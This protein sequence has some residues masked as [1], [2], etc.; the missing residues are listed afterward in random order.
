MKHLYKMGGVVTSILLIF[1]LLV[2]GCNSGD[3]NEE[4]VEESQ[5]KVVSIP[6]GTYTVSGF[7]F[8]VS[9]SNSKVTDSD[10]KDV[11]TIDS[12]GK[13]TINK[14]ESE[15]WEITYDNGDIVLVK[16]EKGSSAKTTYRGSISGDELVNV[17]NSGD[18]LSFDAEISE[19]GFVSAKKYTVTVTNGTA[20]PASAK[21]GETVT[22]SADTPEDGFGFYKWTSETEG[23]TLANE[24][25]S[26]T[27]FVMPERDVSITA[28]YK[29]KA[30]AP[31]ITQENST[32]M[33]ASEDT[34]SDGKIANEAITTLMEYSTDDG[35]TWISVESDG[36]I[37]N[38]CSGTILIRVKATEEKAPSDSVSVF[39]GAKERAATP[40]ISAE[41][42]TITKPSTATSTNGKIENEAITTAMEYSTNG[43]ETWHDVTTSGEIANLGAGTVLIRVK[44]TEEKA[45]S[46]S[47]SIVVGEKSKAQTPSISQENSTVTKV[48]AES[49]SDGKIANEAITT[50][51]EYSTDDGETW[52]DVTTAGEIANLA[53][54][55]V[56]V[57]TKESAEYAPSD[58]VSIEIGVM[59]YTVTITN[60]TASVAS[61]KAGVEVTVTANAAPENKVF[62]KW[63]SEG[64]ATFADEKSSE[65][66]FTMPAGN[67]SITA[68]YKDPWIGT[69]A[70]DEPKAVGDIVFYDGSATPY[71]ADL[72]LTEEE[73]LAAIAVIFYVGTE[74]SNADSSGN[75]ASR[76]LGVGLVDGSELL[77]SI[78]E[79]KG[80]EA[81]ITT[82]QC[83]PSGTVDNYT[84]TGDL[85]GSDNFDAIAA[86]PG[87]NDTGTESN[88]PAFYFAKN[89]K[90][91]KVGEESSSRI[92]AGSSFETGWYVP[93]IAELY[94]VYENRIILNKARVLCGGL[95]FNENQYCSSSQFAG[96]AWI[97]YKLYFYY[98]TVKDNS[99]KSEYS[100]VCAIRE[101]N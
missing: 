80:K 73:K 39:V 48:S 77:W 79:A 68:T 3:N 5:P 4:N 61:A 2:V 46:L 69:K 28:T 85:D 42:S 6:D 43:G 20:N 94:Q 31:E 65:T 36:E 14:S 35:T 51:M 18:K 98:G 84:F 26:P 74:C 67:V 78:F 59:I 71:S 25:A 52:R 30:I 38:L 90:N 49:E 56:L 57:R 96:N 32:I 7:K 93:S 101:F 92:P 76:T 60:G 86:F 40:A 75:L 27:T 13:I 87:V 19:S 83:T 66:T 41:N 70:P 91:Q 17:E 55:T 89:Y 58:S 99:V 8:T 21:K 29:E 23:L 45:P 97:A 100:Y 12:D 9:K 37:E 81:N 54:G 1:A 62:A 11:G 88:Y 63:T 95:R 72:T 24:S 22:I 44:A 10:G 64:G 16:I 34:V 82:I 53:A 50:S 33:I 47:V 15:T